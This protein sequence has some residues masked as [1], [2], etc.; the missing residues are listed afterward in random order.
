[1]DARRA[2]ILQELDL[3]PLWTR[4]ELLAE[5]A[6]QAEQTTVQSDSPAP[7][8]AF[9]DSPEAPSFPDRPA[10][11]VPADTPDSRSNPPAARSRPAI[12]IQPTRQPQQG[13]IEQAPQIDRQ[14]RAARIATLEWDA[15]Q[16]EVA[17]CQACGLCKS[18]TRTV[19]GVGVPQ[20]DW[21]VVGEAPGAEEDRQGQPFVGQAGKLL[22]SMLASVGRSRQEN[23]FI[24]NVLK[25][26]PPQNRNP[27]PDEVALCL[28]F[29][30]RQIEL[31]QPKLIFAV[32]RF[33]AQALLGQDGPISALRS[34]VHTPPN[35][36]PV[37]V[38]Y[39]PAY[40]LRNPPDK[41]KSW[42]D[43]LLA[44]QTLESQH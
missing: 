38:S 33:A 13:S 41:I 20:A 25:C 23:V 14:A 9:P 21:M 37:V 44:K 19:F 24:A 11:Q 3:T 2:L 34:R 42:A 17:A 29:L 30:R 8:N 35:S 15:L 6:L 36:A 27:Q 40:L 28:P 32:G 18:R 5:A 1:M 26:R 16:T 4:R 12:A 7:V 22:D 43:L 39:H 10:P 31:I